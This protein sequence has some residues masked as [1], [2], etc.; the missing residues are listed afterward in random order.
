VSAENLIG[1]VLAAALIVFLIAALL[2]PE[3]F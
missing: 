3:R 2:Y 1:L